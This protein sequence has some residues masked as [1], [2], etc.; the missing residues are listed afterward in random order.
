MLIKN[1]PTIEGSG[2][3]SFFKGLYYR[4]I[5]CTNCNNFKI[6]NASTEKDLAGPYLCYKC[7]TKLNK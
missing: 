6:T 5:G 7:Q 3:V 1:Q 2:P 4:Q